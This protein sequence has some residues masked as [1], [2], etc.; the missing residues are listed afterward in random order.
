MS[1][2]KQSSRRWRLIRLLHRL[3]GITARD[4]ARDFAVLAELSIQESARRTESL[5]TSQ[6]WATERKRSGPPRSEIHYYRNT[7]RGL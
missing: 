3:R 1:R 7:K 5:C 2:G 6:V 4:A